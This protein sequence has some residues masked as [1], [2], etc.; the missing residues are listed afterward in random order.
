MSG[1]ITPIAIAA[2][3]GCQSSAGEDSESA[4]P[5]LMPIASSR[6]VESIGYS[7]SGIRKSNRKS[8]AARATTKAITGAVKMLSTRMLERIMSVLLS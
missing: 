4:F 1:V 7:A 3:S 8:V 5:P 2:K 6:K